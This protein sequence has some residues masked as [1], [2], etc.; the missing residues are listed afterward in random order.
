[1]IILKCI[2][3]ITQQ[4]LA[5]LATFGMIAVTVPSSAQAEDFR[6]HH[7]GFKN[8]GF[9]GHHRGHRNNRN[10]SGHRHY[11]GHRNFRGH[12]KFN[13]HRGFSGYRRGYGHNRGF[14]RGH[15]RAVAAGIIGFTA[16]AII[17]SQAG[18]R[19]H[20]PHRRYS[21]HVS[22]RPWTPGWFRACSRKY[23]SFNPQTGRYLSYSGKHRLCR[24]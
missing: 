22:Y 13:G 7:G 19:H 18:K 21:S 9:K 2:T 6:S 3:R 16:G 1:M 17:A 14:H 23:R 10:F 8:G 5:A 4:S 20:R 24:I 11:R 15:N 12:R